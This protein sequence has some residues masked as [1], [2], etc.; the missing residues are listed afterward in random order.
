MS[1]VVWKGVIAE[2]PPAYDIDIDDFGVGSA[3]LYRQW[4]WVSARD[5]S[6]RIESMEQHPDFPWLKRSTA[7]IKR[8]EANFASASITF[9]GIPPNTDKRTY[10]MSASLGSAPI[11]THPNF[12]S[13]ITEGLVTF[14]PEDGAIIWA[15]KDRKGLEN[16]LF[17][18]ESWLQPSMTYE[19]VWVRGSTGSS[20]DFRTIGLID[21]PP[22]SD[23]RPQTPDGTNFLFMGGDIEL[24]GDGTKMIRRWKLSSGGPWSERLYS[25]RR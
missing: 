5:A 13:L 4:E 24:I 14:D 10:R 16:T 18:T 21:E 8:E 12:Q 25:K 23:V 7:R 2:E 9:V 3:T 11:T 17:G 15:E 6:S 19:E 20:R 1:Q 22:K